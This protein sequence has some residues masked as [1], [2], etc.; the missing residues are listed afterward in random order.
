VR[1]R[2]VAVLLCCVG[3]G[4][5]GLGCAGL[6]AGTAT[7]PDWVDGAPGAYPAAAWVSAAS[8]GSTAGSARGNARAEL[9][10]V[11]HSRVE[12]EV[13]DRSESTIR[14][15]GDGRARTAAAEELI[16]KL[17]VDTRV[18]TEGD[19][20]GVRVA[21]VWQEPHGGIWHAL[22]V[23]N[24]AELRKA[25]AAEI[26]EAGRRV[27][28]DLTRA[29][30]GP[31]PLGVAR[32]LLDASRAGRERDVLVAR[33]RV[34]GAPRDDFR[35]TTAE[36]DQ[37]LDA[38]LWETRFQIR[39]QEVDPSSGGVKG[40]LPRLRE[41]F[42]ERI[43][44]IGF[45]IAGNG[46][47]ADMLVAIRMVLEE[48]PRDFDGHFVRWEGSYEVTGAAPDG[49]VVMSSQASGG[50]SYPTLSVARTRALAKGSQQLAGDLQNQISRYLQEREDH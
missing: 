40:Q 8:S 11:F 43:T 15:A 44:G 6:G 46:E 9:S 50:E 37:R 47:Q 34:A 16:E 30:S 42:E 7:R 25:L 24:K 45:R 2:F 12:S 14:S 36:I 13:R 28:G 48:V 26:V 21:E 3:A 31:T 35:P 22:A 4:F 19:F 23:V 5:A 33:A 29:D 1:R 39:A 32:A 27:N 20:E 10:R 18:S 49:A 17:E 38:V 41:A